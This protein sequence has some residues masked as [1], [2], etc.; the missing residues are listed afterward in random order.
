MAENGVKV[1]PEDKVV[2]ELI[3]DPI[4]NGGAGEAIIVRRAPVIHVV[5]DGKT[6]E[7]RSWAKTVS[8]A[9][10]EAS[11]P[12][13]PKDLI[14]P[15]GTTLIGNGA[16][17]VVT[18]INEVEEEKEVLVPFATTYKDDYW[19]PKGQNKVTTAGV[20]GSKK[21]TFKVVYKNGVEV[22]RKL[23]SESV[24]SRPVTEVVSRG[25]K[26][27]GDKYNRWPI[28]VAAG[29]KYGVSPDEMFNV[30][31]CESKGYQ[32]AGEYGPY[33]GIFQWDGSFSTWATKAGF[34]GADIFDVTAQA[35]ATAL[36]VSKSGWAAWGCKP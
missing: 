30:M 3:M 7:V 11:F 31:M 19:V 8:E 14:E 4:K 24:V 21:Q 17:V 1:F 23:L 27:S 16:Y 20:S 28:L 13:G 35:Y 2:I 6:T 32:Y 18:R 22:S 33:K 34:A 29:T 10:A 12:V 9:L 25:L 26:P 15:K 36:R 5:A